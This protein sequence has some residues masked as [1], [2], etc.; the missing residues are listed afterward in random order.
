MDLQGQLTT[1]LRVTLNYVGCDMS[2]NRSGEYETSINEG[3]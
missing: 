1:A 2:A 3:I